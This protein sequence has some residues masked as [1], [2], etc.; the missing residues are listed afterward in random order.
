MRSYI[1]R[2]K[3]MTRFCARMKI[4]SLGPHRRTG[5][6]EQF[7]KSFL[8]LAPSSLLKY[9]KFFE[10]V[11][12]Q[13]QQRPSEHFADSLIQALIDALFPLET[14]EQSAIPNGL[15]VLVTS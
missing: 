4:R 3:A 5:F 1:R 11:Y 12:A 14:D 15:H 13:W 6:M 10:P 9:P 2:L 7:A 8:S